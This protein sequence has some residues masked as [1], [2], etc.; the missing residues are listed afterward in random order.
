M[1]DKKTITNS[2]HACALYSGDTKNKLTICEVHR[3]LYQILKDTDHMTDEVR[4]LL[5]QGFVMGKK[6]HYRL[7]AY[8]HDWNEDIYKE[9]VDNDYQ[10]ITQSEPIE[11]KW[12]S[13]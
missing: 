1:A 4:Y 11:W 7:A 13:K 6:I 10:K 8:K 9:K 12:I 2:K 3:K 5:E